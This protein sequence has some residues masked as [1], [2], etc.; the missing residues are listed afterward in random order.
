[1]KS[2]S[3]SDCDTVGGDLTLSSGRHVKD[4]TDVPMANRHCE[5]AARMG[6]LLPKF[7][8]RTGPLKGLLV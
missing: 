5:I 6:L 8:D 3:L 7:A 2:C 4:G 1:M